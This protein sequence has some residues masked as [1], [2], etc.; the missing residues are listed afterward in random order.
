MPRVC[1]DHD[2]SDPRGDLGYPRRGGES[3]DRRGG[4][5]PKRA[6]RPETPYTV[7]IPWRTRFSPTWRVVVTHPD[8]GAVTFLGPVEFTPG[9]RTTAVAS[10]SHPYCGL[11][12]AVRLRM[13]RYAVE[14]LDAVRAPS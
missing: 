4:G 6:P 5:A 11:P 8:Y 13:V 9:L 1:G 10:A 14:A 7:G 3:G 2:R 12:G